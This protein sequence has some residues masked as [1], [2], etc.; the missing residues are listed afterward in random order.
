MSSILV[1]NLTGKT[2]AG[3][4]TVKSE[5][6]AATMQLQQGLMKAWMRFT[7]VS[8][9]AA[10]DSFNMSVITDGGTGNTTLGITSAMGNANF[11]AT[12]YT[13]FDATTGADAFDA[14]LNGRGFGLVGRSTTRIQHFAFQIDSAVNDV[15][16][17]GD[18]A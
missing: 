7:G 9:T 10:L 18:L 5:G 6:G 15:Q 4:V 16:I 2:T 3:S 17:A 13:N 11:S 8:T 14:D 1:D 12:G